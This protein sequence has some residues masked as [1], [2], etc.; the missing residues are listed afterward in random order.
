MKHP[1]P[2]PIRALCNSLP[3]G[4]SELAKE[5]GVTRQSVYSWMVGKKSPG[6]KSKRQLVDKYSIDI[7]ELTDLD[8]D[9]TQHE[10]G[11][12]MELA[13]EMVKMI[14]E[15]NELMGQ[16]LVGRVAAIETQGNARI[17]AIE[18]RLKL[19]SENVLAIDRNSNQADQ[20]N[21]GRLEHLEE[22]LTYLTKKLLGESD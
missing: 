11:G 18:D 19:L 8:C 15:T 13:R 9:S 3:G 17:G 21:A 4:V 7:S 16:T 6:P 2:N 1:N 22:R 12:E 10:E 5:I 20:I 14:R